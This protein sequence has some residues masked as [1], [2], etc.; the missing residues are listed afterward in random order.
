MY[1]GQTVISNLHFILILHFARSA[2]TRL[3]LLFEQSNP[4]KKY[5]ACAVHCRSVTMYIK[6]LTIQGFKSYRDQVVVDPFRWGRILET[7]P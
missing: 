7:L 6:S 1:L 2:V 3:P 4:S 5:T